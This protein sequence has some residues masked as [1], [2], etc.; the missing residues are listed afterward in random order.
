M[1]FFSVLLKT[2]DDTPGLPRWFSGK[3]FTCQ[4]RRLRRHGFDPEIRKIPWSRKWQPSPVFLPEKSHEQRSLAGYSLWGRKES[5]TTV[6]LSTCVHTHTHTHT[7]WYARVDGNGEEDNKGDE[8]PD[9]GGS[10]ELAKD[11][12]SFLFTSNVSTRS[13]E[14]RISLVTTLVFTSR[15]CTALG[16]KE[17]QNN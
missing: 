15:K 2:G 1:D 5:D 12:I 11:T 13:Q 14:L 9:I 17:N 3:E 16:T 6:W 4:C 8:T 10:Q 7:R